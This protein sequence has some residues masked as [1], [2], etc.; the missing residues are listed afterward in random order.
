VC[1]AAA[2]SIPGA[3]AVPAG[4]PGR[5]ARQA[6]LPALPAQALAGLEHQIIAQVLQVV[7]GPAAA[8]FLRR[9]LLGKPLGGPSLP[10]DVG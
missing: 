3:A 7:S 6:E 1:T 8:S 5:T 9:Q 2:P 4:L 10:L